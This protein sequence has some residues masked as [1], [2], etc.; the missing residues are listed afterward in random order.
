MTAREA[1]Q[2]LT[3]SLES[4]GAYVRDLRAR[5][6]QGL[7]PPNELLSAEAQQSRERVVSIEA[8]TRA[9]SP[10]PICGACS[11]LRAQARSSRR[12]VWSHWLR[13]LAM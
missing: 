11:G 8:R 5:L 1:E 7:I 12:R 6:D 2:V 13:P 4:I 10:K 3:R 9:G